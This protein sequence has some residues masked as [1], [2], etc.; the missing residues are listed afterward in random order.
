MKNLLTKILATALIT[1]PGVTLAQSY[2]EIINA[3]FQQATDFF[4]SRGYSL[5]H[6]PSGGQLGHNAYENI[7]INL[8]S[9][10]VYAIVAFC[11]QNCDNINLELYDEKNN[12]IDSD[13]ETDAKPIVQVAPEWTGQFL[14]KVTMA[15]CSNVPCHYGA[16]V[17]GKQAE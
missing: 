8:S 4:A 16:A 6:G 11:D 14:I 12:L 13:T 17:Y 15:N 9:G 5:T 3:Q 7:T 1:I 10:N 2:V